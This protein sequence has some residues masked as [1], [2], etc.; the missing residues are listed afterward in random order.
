MEKWVEIRKSG[1]FKKIGETYG[2]D[3]VIARVMRNRGVETPEQA[4]EY[5]HG[6]TLYAPSLLL[7]LDKA[8]AILTEKIKQKKKIRIIGDYDID[9]ISATYILL[10]GF[11]TLGGDADTVIPHRLRD[12]YGVNVSLIEQAVSDGIDTVV[13]CDNGIAALDAVQSAKDAGMTVIVTDHHEVPYTEV[14]GERQ[15]ELVNADAIVDPKREGDPYP[16]KD[17]CGATVAWKLIQRLYEIFGLPEEKSHVFMENAAF[18]TVGDVMDLT[19]ENRTIVRLGLERLE[20]TANPGMRALMTEKEIK[21]SF[22][23]A[24]HIGFVLGPCINASGRLDTAKR[25]LD[26]LCTRN[27]EEAILAAKELAALNESRKDM[28]SQGVDQARELIEKEHLDRD[29]V[30]LVF[31]PDCHES[32][33]GI[34]AGRI[35]ETYHH[36]VIVLT[37]AE[38]G[39]IKGSGR[40]IEAY[41]M[42]EELTKCK[43]LFLK[44]GGHPMA[45][46]L[47]MKEE[48]LPLL[49]ERLNAYTT[50]TE[51]DL[52]NTIKIDAVVPLS[53]LTESF[54]TQLSEL[55]PF[56]KGNEKPVFAARDIRVTSMRI[57]GKNRNVLRLDLCTEAGKHMTGVHFGEEDQLEKMIQYIK[58]KGSVVSMLYYPRIDDFNGFSQVQVQVQAVR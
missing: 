44:Y 54:V 5:L 14:S 43:D 6:E 38:D 41:S 7:D 19:G 46:G 53:Y 21:P 32:L 24:Y 47:S 22:L 52:V 34:I 9:G 42:Y 37:R 8:A 35:R 31:L 58:E 13:T 15:F 45:A 28:T 27:R 55:E 4:E 10:T 36:P 20:H 30:M 26:L 51:E 48:N 57:C 29:P 3:P 39:D 1:D 16:C 33:A 2:I 56:G 18:A 50:L 11:R 40:S 23:R 49:R 25:S 17:I 12:G